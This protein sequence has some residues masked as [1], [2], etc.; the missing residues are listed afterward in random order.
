V[1]VNLKFIIMPKTNSLLELIKGIIRSGNWSRTILLKAAHL[2]EV[3]AAGGKCCLSIIPFSR[4]G[5]TDNHCEYFNSSDPDN[6]DNDPA[7]Q[8]YL[9]FISQEDGSF[10]YVTVPIE[11][12]PSP[13]S[14]RV[15]ASGTITLPPNLTGMYKVALSLQTSADYPAVNFVDKQGVIIDTEGG[16]APLFSGNGIAITTNAFDIETLGSFLFTNGCSG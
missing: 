16:N 5:D 9:K 6:P 4:V 14:F 11:S 3:A 2:L 8:H 12:T 13:G 15:A 10:F 1:V 7:F